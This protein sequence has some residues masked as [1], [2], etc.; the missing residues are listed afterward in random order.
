MNSGT[1]ISVSKCACLC[2][3]VGSDVGIRNLVQVAKVAF[4][5]EEFKYGLLNQTSHQYRRVLVS[6]RYK[7]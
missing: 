7:V 2:G 1:R 4:A 6:V 5:G 3:C